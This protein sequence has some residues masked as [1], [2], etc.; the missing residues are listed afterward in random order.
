MKIIRSL[1]KEEF[2]SEMYHQDATGKHA[3][4]LKNQ[5]E[6]RSYPQQDW[7]KIAQF[8]TRASE[9]Y[10]PDCDPFLIITNLSINF[11]KCEHFPEEEKRVKK[12]AELITSFP[13]IFVSLTS[14]QFN[15]LKE[16]QPPL[17]VING[18]HRVEAAKLRKNNT[19]DVIM[20]QEAW[21]FFNQWL[22]SF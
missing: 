6:T 11:L 19:I 21:Y 18:N 14:Y 4:W 8:H 17:T 12:Y 13:P 1:T 5:Y 7:G 2:I 16:S 15:N 10:A 3:D 9:Q 20:S 22:L